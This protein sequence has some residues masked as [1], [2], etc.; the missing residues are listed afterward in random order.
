MVEILKTLYPCLLH[1]LTNHRNICQLS[2][3]QELKMLK[4]RAS[5]YSFEVNLLF[6]FNSS[7]QQIT[8]YKQHS[9]WHVHGVSVTQAY[10]QQCLSRKTS[11]HFLSVVWPIINEEKII[12]QTGMD[13]VW[14]WD[15]KNYKP[16]SDT[17][18]LQGHRHWLWRLCLS[19]KQKELQLFNFWISIMLKIYLLHGNTLK[20]TA[21]NESVCTCVC[22]AKTPSQQLNLARLWKTPNRW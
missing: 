8:N 22:V 4:Q 7:A 1:F 9:P 6:F 3:H 11:S 14:T 10:L 17:V 12:S 21:T 5:C 2:S 20:I 16:K 13:T 15:V 18:C 19:R